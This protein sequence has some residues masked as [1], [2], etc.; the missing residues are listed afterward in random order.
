MLTAD[1]MRCL[2]P[3]HTV[4]ISQLQDEGKQLGF[5][6]VDY[7]FHTLSTSVAMTE[8][9]VSAHLDLISSDKESTTKDIAFHALVKPITTKSHTIAHQTGELR[10]R[11]RLEAKKNE[12]RASM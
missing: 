3:S 2:A 11:R 6:G 8:E 5:V 1:N 7:G 9:H 4:D 10:R 12:V